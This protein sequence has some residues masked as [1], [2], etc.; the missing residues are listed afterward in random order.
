MVSFRTSL[1]ALLTE[2]QRVFLDQLDARA[3]SE[4]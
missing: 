1:D 2:V 4:K 3:A